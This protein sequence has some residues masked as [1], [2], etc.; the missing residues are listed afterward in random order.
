MLLKSPIRLQCRI[1][2]PAP[3][4]AWRPRY[5]S[6][7]LISTPCLMIVPGRITSDFGI[8]ES[9]RLPG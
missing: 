4:Y 3:M 1:E 9:M 5:S 8:T 7:S 6:V 2:A